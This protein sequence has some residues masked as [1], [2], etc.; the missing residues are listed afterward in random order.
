ME[1]ERVFDQTRH[2]A[3]EVRSDRYTMVN[4]FASVRPFGGVRPVSGTRSANNLF[5]MEARRDASVLKD[6]APLANRHLPVSVRGGLVTHGFDR[7]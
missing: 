1:V 6:S 7:W 3:F 2:A 5:D 4:L